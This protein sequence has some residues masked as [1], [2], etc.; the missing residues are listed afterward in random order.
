MIKG[1]D[2]MTMDRKEFW[3]M[4]GKEPHKD[5]VLSIIRA[6]LTEE[7]TEELRR[8]IHRNVGKTQFRVCCRVYWSVDDQWY[9]C[10][11]VDYF[12]DNAQ[13]LTVACV[14]RDAYLYI[15]EPTMRRHRDDSLTLISDQRYSKN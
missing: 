11:N 7:V 6:A 14:V 8:N 3:A 1:E 13:L 2:Y 9:L 10:V 5:K 15:D 4:F 12:F